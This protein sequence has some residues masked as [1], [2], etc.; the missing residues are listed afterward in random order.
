MLESVKKKQPLSVENIRRIFE[1]T[2]GNNYFARI[3]W[4]YAL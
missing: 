1:V 3:G 2:G 4:I